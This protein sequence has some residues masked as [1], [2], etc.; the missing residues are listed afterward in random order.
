MVNLLS[1]THIATLFLGFDLKIRRF[2]PSCTEFLSLIDTDI[3]RPIS[4]LSL[5]V[6][7]ANLKQDVDRVIGKLTPV[8]AEVQNDRGLWF[9]RRVLPYRTADNKIEG[10]V[11]TYTDITALK[12]AAQKLESRE[13]Q[14]AAVAALGCTALEDPELQVLFDRG[15]TVVAEQLNCEFSEVLALLPGRGSLLQRAG[16]GW[17]AG[18]SGRISP[19]TGIESLAGYALQ[20]AGP[21]IVEDWPR[22][23]A[24]ACRRSTVS[25][26]SSALPAS[27]LVRRTRAGE[28]FACSPPRSASSLWTT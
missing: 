4:D 26:A 27:S 2:A 17:K 19:A 21:V 1:S 20:T 6:A 7:D 12:L 5:R 18:S 10:V 22:R 13:H 23:S 16:T 24:L 3:G 14:Q 9:L 11:V 8:E 25:T 28:R 15:A